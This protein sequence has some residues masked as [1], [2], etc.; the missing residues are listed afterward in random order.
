LSTE[1]FAVA[2]NAQKH[3]TTFQG[4]GQVPMPA[5]AHEYPPPSVVDRQ[6]WKWKWPI[7]CCYFC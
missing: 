5:D 2:T 7:V 6:A 1:H 4:W 3:F